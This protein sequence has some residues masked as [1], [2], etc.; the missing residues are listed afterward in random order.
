MI[1]AAIAESREQ[2][3]SEVSDIEYSPSGEGLQFRFR[4]ETF[5][6]REPYPEMVMPGDAIAPEWCIAEM[7]REGLQPLEGGSDA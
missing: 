7:I 2:L 5:Q 1:R 6:T 3:A 4:G